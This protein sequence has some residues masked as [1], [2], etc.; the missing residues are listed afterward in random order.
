MSQHQWARK[1]D[2]K[3]YAEYN[4]FYCTLCAKDKSIAEADCHVAAW[5]K[6]NDAVRSYAEEKKKKPRDK[7]G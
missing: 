1:N 6:M 7:R 2:D 4:I 3:N 5:L